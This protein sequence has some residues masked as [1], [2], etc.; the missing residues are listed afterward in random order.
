MTDRPIQ[1]AINGAGGRMGQ[2]LIALAGEDARFE[3]AGAIEATGHPF[4]GTTMGGIAYEDHLTRGVDVVVDFSLPAGTQRI[5]PAAINDKTA[6]VI[7]T[8]GFGPELQCLVDEAAKEIPIVHAPNFSVGVNVLLKLLAIA[9]ARLGDAYDVEIVETHHRFKKDA[10]SGTALALA[11]CICDA[12]GRDMATALRH[13]RQGECP[14]VAGEIGIHAVRVG[15]TVGEHA[16]HFGTLGETVTLS[17]SAHSRDTFALGALRAA[18][19]VVGKAPGAYDMA[20][21]L[22]GE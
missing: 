19:W 17:H 2:R 10:P 5:L 9:A 3:V 6:M 16:V 14:R 7:G 11:E 13:G 21:M 8:T 20:D 15:D 12:T 22:F 4:I 1:L 18:A